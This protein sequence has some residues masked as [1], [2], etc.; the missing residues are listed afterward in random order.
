MHGTYWHAPQPKLIMVNTDNG[1]IC[2]I[3]ECLKRAQWSVRE[4]GQTMRQDLCGKHL[5]AAIGEVVL[6]EIV[7]IRQRPAK[8]GS[9]P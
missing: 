9:R 3:R 4:D 1:K 2:D 8:D 6:V 7:P 5:D